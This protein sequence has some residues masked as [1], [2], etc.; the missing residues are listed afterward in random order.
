MSASV[1][2]EGGHGIKGISKYEKT[3]GRQCNGTSLE[4]FNTR[5]GMAGAT[6]T[7]EGEHVNNDSCL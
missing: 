2:H 1:K 3:E 4:C 7:K 5:D 6:P